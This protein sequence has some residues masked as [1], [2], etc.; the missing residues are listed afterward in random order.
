MFT[1][2]DRKGRSISLRPEGTA[3]VVRSY[4][5]NKLFLNK[6]VKKFFYFGPMFRAEKPQKG[7]LRQFNQFGVEAF[8][9]DSPLLDAEIIKMHI[10]IFN[11]LKLN[12]LE[13]KINSVGCKNCM[14]SYKEKLK[15]FL[16]KNK[17]FLCEDCK[18]R[19]EKNPLRVFDCKNEKCQT[20]YKDAPK[21][22]DNLCPDCLKHFEELKEN[23]NYYEI[24]YK[25]EP[26]LVRGFDYY[27]RTVFEITASELGS[28]NAI[29]GG[30]RYNDLIENLTN[31]ERSEPAVGAACGV[32]RLILLLKT[33]NEKFEL[34]SK[35]SLYIANAGNIDKKLIIK[36]AQ[37]F[38]RNN[39]IVHLNYFNKNLKNQLDEA[40]K[41]G[42]DFVLIL[43]EDELSK[44]SITLRDMKK[45]EQSLVKVLNL[46][47][48]VEVIEILKK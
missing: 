25:F 17:E 32:E 1:F 6:G 29:L 22:V 30:G 12:N 38:I 37:F 3:G 5:E 46:E 2:E 16:L 43:G 33:K 39:I 35:K 41:I 26:N 34:P 11:N 7:R 9:A 8:G 48:P 44:S 45:S 20:I 14:P 42:I 10:E 31:G 27:T 19:S 23:L 36:L 21:I 28:Q 40:N 24:E 13:V 15:S 18:I 4:I 47:T